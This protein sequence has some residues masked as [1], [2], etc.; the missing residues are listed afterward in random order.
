MQLLLVIMSCPEI[1]LH[2]SVKIWKDIQKNFRQNGNL[3]KRLL[4]DR[5][6]FNILVF[7]IPL[8]V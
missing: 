2:K 1:G 8:S 6:S 4:A 7:L 5:Y 3:A